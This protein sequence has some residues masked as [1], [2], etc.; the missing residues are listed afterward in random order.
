VAGI[1]IVVV[2]GLVPHDPPFVISELKSTVMPARAAL[3][4]PRQVSMGF[5]LDEDRVVATTARES[6]GVY[7]GLLMYM[8]IVKR[9]GLVAPTRES[10]RYLVQWSL[11]PGAELQ[12]CEDAAAGFMRQQAIAEGADSWNGAWFEDG[13]NV[14]EL[15]VV[16]RGRVIVSGYV[17]NVVALIVGVVCVIALWMSVVA[18]VGVRKSISRLRRGA[19]VRCGYSIEGV[20]GCPECGLGGT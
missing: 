13:A 18:W 8:R 5:W 6:E 7:L 2:I 10:T 19:C 4:H 1:G 3:V 20:G 11:E 15:G 12:A 9:E 17:W 16:S 14:I